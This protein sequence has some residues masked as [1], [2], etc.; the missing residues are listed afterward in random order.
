[1]LGGKNEKPRHSSCYP[2][3]FGVDLDVGE[4]KDHGE[5]STTV[6]CNSQRPQ[7]WAKTIQ[8]ASNEKGVRLPHRCTNNSIDRRNREM[9]RENIKNTCSALKPYPPKPEGAHVK[10]FEPDVGDDRFG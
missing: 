3:P 1:M 9:S 4:E 7:T 6:N 5:H 8:N 2:D 10:L